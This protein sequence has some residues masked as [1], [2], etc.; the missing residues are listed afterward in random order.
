MSDYICPANGN[1]KYIYAFVR[2][3]PA[4]F[5]GFKNFNLIV[6]LFICP[7]LSGKNLMEMLGTH[8]AGQSP[9]NSY[10]YNNMR[11]HT[12]THTHTHI[13]MYQYT[14]THTHTHIHSHILHNIISLQSGEPLFSDPTAILSFY[15]TLLHTYI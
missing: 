4:K 14:H 9:V 1:A 8:F 13:M 15:H 12:H 5:D 11:A 2:Q 10:Y 6:I 3:C 7:L